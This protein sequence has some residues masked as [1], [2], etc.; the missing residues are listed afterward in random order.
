[1][2]RP[3]L[4]AALGLALAL[5][6]RAG[7]DAG[8]PAAGKPVPESCR[9]CKRQD[10]DA[11]K[12]AAWDQSHADFLAVAKKGGVDLLFLGD[13]ITNQWREQGK[14]VWDKHFAPLA[15]ANFGI[16]GDQ[17]QNVLWRVENGELEGLAPKLVVLMIGTNNTAKSRHSPEDI[18]AGVSAILGVVRDKCPQAKVLLLGIFPTK[19]EPE[20]FYRVNND[21]TNTLLA[22]LDDGG[23]TIRFLNINDKL[24]ERDRTIT[25]EMFPDL[26]HL[27]EKGYTIWAEAIVGTVR[28][29]M[30]LKP[31]EDRKSQA[32]AEK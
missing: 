25:R 24:M 31:A 13:S 19:V 7:E 23:K 17:T 2:M 15:A 30:G 6:A 26:L 3:G 28:E 29:M 14:P 9:P 11:V 8:Q 22:K 10:G 5:A 20:N 27:S 21:R 12:K 1:M 18:A 16:N 4:V 32:P